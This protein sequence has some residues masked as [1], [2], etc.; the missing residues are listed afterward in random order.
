MSSWYQGDGCWEGGL[1]WTRLDK[2]PLALRNAV[3]PRG[4]ALPDTKS[5]RVYFDP[6]EAYDYNDSSVLRR[7]LNKAE[8]ALTRVKPGLTWDDVA[9]TVY[10][11]P[12]GIENDPRHGKYQRGAGF[13]A[14]FGI[15]M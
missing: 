8:A 2:C 6:E 15:T 5:L 14:D 1:Y 11:Y 4:V 3:D 13:Y 7:V 12:G 10:Y 9:V